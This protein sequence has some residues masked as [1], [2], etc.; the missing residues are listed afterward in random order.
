MKQYVFND[1]ESIS[2]VQRIELAK[3]SQLQ[4]DS[5]QK[6]QELVRGIHRKF[7][8]EVIKWLREIG[9]DLQGLSS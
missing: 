6:Y 7:H 5:S 3:L 2:L 1:T 9:V 4:D 8:Y